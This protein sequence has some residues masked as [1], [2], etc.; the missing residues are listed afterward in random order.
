MSKKTEYEAARMECFAIHSALHDLYERIQ[1]LPDRGNQPEIM[2]SEQDV[3]DSLRRMHS[4]GNR[5]GALAH[6]EPQ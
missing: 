1:A 3:L 6:E 4:A 5:Y 2:R